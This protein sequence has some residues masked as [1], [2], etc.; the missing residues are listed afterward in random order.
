M[1]FDEAVASHD[2]KYP[3]AENYAED[4]KAIFEKLKPRWIPVS[5]RLPDVDGEYPI[6]FFHFSGWHK[7]TFEK[8][9]WLS[10]NAISDWLE[11]PDLPE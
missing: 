3:E 1:T 6:R 11:I 5:E 9:R 7:G 4:Y 10:G 8:G 2:F